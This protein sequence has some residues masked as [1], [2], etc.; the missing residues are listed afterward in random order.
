MQLKYIYFLFL[1]GLVGV[2]SSLTAQITNAHIWVNEF[3]YDEVTVHGEPDQT[4]FVELVV[5][6][7]ILDNPI[8]AAKVKL[9]LYTANG[10]SFEQNPD[11]ARGL[12]YH[13]SSLIYSE[14]AT[15]HPIANNNADGSGDNFRRCT[16]AGANYSFLSKDLP[17]LQD[18]TAGFA[19]IYNDEV[20]AQFISYEGRFKA[21]DCPAAGA[22]RGMTTDLIDALAETT[23]TDDEHSIQLTG[24]ANTYGTFSWDGDNAL[25]AT[26]CSEN[27]N[28]VI[29]DLAC[30]APSIDDPGTLTATSC[31]NPFTLPAIE[32]SFLSGNEAY[33]D[34][35]QASGTATVITE[36]TGATTVYIYD[37][38]GT[39]CG[40][41]IAVIV[42]CNALAVDLLDFT[43][44]LTDKNDAALQWLTANET[45]FSHFEVFRSN[46][47]K[48]WTNLGKEIAGSNHYEFVDANLLS[49]FKGGTTLYYRLKMV[50]QDGSFEWSA[51]KTII[52][53]TKAGQMEVYPN[54]SDG[55]VTVLLSTEQSQAA[56]L[57]VV[58]ITG[59]LVQQFKLDDPSALDSYSLD[60]SNLPKGIYFLQIRLVEGA[61]QRKVVLE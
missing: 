54:P 23:S 13:E 37:E 16:P 55:Q 43:V 24:T 44:Q 8:E 39:G 15:I 27:E 47:N 26:K 9:V 45:N 50:N 11:F 31:S 57:R 56:Q 34:L 52:L 17:S 59:Q 35:P 10:L 7:Q 30:I 29:N 33:Y 36:I 22:A 6:N 42:E 48:A 18:V 25:R 5:S 32:G 49:Q 58:S 2:Q 38:N 28:Q 4:E 46:N 51:T 20:V 12:P 40:Q 60:L 3:H 61:Q 41:E 1:L 53:P 14:A 21:C 19:L